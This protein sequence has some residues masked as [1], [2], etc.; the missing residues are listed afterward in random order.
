MNTY[1]CKVC[2]YVEEVEGKPTEKCFKCGALPENFEEVVGEAKDKIYASDRTN[3]IYCEIIENIMKIEKLSQEGKEIGLDPNCVK[4]FD[5]FINLA[6][7][8][9]Q[10]SKAE[11]AAHMTKGKW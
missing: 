9:K 11:M 3:D 5:C 10:V 6:W 4:A 1:K 7:Q 2:G 8:V